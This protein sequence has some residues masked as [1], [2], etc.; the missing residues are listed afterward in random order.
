MTVGDRQVKLHL[1][2]TAGQERFHSLIPNYIRDSA[3]AVIVYDVTS[4]FNFFHQEGMHLY[5]HSL[6]RNSF[7]NV[8]RWYDE[9]KQYREH[10]II[11]IVG[12]KTDLPSDK[13]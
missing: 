10:A 4:L 9:V 7:A 2:D 12:N 3:I 1:W 5:I 11:A 6:D 13:K 8:K